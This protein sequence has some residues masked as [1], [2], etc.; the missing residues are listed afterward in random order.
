MENI[1]MTSPKPMDS[2][3]VILVREPACGKFEIC[4][5]KRRVELDFMGGVYVFPGGI[6]D[7]EDCDEALIQHAKGISPLVKK[8]EMHEPDMPESKLRGIVFS[9]IRETF[10]ESGILLAYDKHGDI[11]NLKKVSDDFLNR[12]GEYRTLV[13]EKK[14]SLADIANREKI[15]YAADMLTPYSR[16][17]TPVTKSGKKR[18]DARFF[19]ARVPVG[20]EALHDHVEMSETVWITPAGA[21]EMYRSGAMALMPP[22][23]RTIEELAGFASVEKLYASAGSKL[24]YAR[25]P[26]FYYFEGGYGIRLPCDPEYSIAEY[27]QPHIPGEPCRIIMGKDGLLRTVLSD[28]D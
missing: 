13:Y 11:I 9:I 24:I 22:T 8:M 4:L 16:W 12:M 14:I 27:K 15:K 3:T 10:E 21:L 1:T 19:I 28:A 18:F 17:I 6:T 7:K 2:A 23:F 20:Q 5:M 25:L 26:E